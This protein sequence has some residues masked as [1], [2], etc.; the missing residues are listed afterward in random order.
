MAAPPRHD[1]ATRWLT[2]IFASRAAAEGGVVRRAAADVERIVGRD[3]FLSEM[4]RRGFT[5]VENA[6][7]IVVFCNRA[8]LR[9]LR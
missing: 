6:G 3:R 9:R 8:P 1:A 4:R 2:Q 5:V 7:Q